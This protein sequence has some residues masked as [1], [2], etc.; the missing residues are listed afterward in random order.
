MRAAVNQPV[1]IAAG[2]TGGHFFPAEA[3]AGALIER[4]ERVVL[5]TDARSSAARSAIFARCEAHVI[6]GAGIAGRNVSR[7]VS[8]AAEI[9]RGVW[10]ARR[11]MAPMSPAV[12]VGFGGYPSV[13]PLLAARSLRRRPTLILHD[14][15]AVLGRANQ[16]LA[17]LCDRIALSFAAT[18]GLPVG[19]AGTLTGN[20]VRP[21]ITAQRRAAY[22]PPEDKIELLVLGGSLGA[23]AF[24]TLIPAA[25]AALPAALRARI[26]LTMQCPQTVVETA[27]SA[28]AACGVNA[29]LAPFFDNVAELLVGAHL[30]IARAG[31]ST[32]A[33]LTVVGRPAILIPLRINA[34]QL[35]NAQA[36]VG[37]GGAVHVPQSEGAPALA[38]A[39]STLLSEPA[40]LAAMA[41]AAGRMG[42]FD[43]AE[44]LATMVGQAVAGRADVP[45][46]RK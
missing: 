38:A 19:V 28:L 16:L 21:A 15:N 26:N 24:A 22:H 25:L 6:P 29:V 41:K 34:D 35:A 30:V 27:R 12:V 11:L 40:R 4:G 32:V 17:R 37:S 13:A 46:V 39:L 44:R 2:G 10:V 45:G 3:L 5:L 42:I 8:G 43:A 23:T 36:L 14:Q 1:V 9:G 20:P 33:E 31:G 7:A 18:A